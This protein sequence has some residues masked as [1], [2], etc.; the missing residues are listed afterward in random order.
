[1]KI[2]IL[3][4][5]D[6][7]EAAEGLTVVIDVF[8]A[9]SV[10]CMA[11][12]NGAGEYLAVGS[13]D[14]ARRLAGEKGSVLMGERDAVM[15]PGFDFGNSPTEIENEDF[16]GRGIVHTTS[17][18]TQGLLAASGADEIV[19]GSFVNA[20]AVARY[21]ESAGYDLVS[22]VALGTAGRERS[23]EDTMCAMF[24]KNEVE[25]YPN[26]FD[27]LRTYLATIPSAAKF[28]DP[29]MTHA[30][31]RDFELCTELDRY[32]FVLRAE[33]EEAD[34]VRLTRLEPSEVD[35]A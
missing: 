26:S 5:L 9:F 31:E 13:E 22:L 32:G 28:F 1:M 19:T 30:P 6:G 3:E 2:Q 8:R 21:I 15:L 33:P 14:T 12:D 20:T 24:I 7:A 25:G 27:A 18:G 16:A 11:V 10:A 17:A 23:M 4:G 29:E 35:H 34:A